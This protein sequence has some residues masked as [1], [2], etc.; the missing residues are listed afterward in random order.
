MKIVNA[1]ENRRQLDATNRC[2]KK[3]RI[4]KP[5]EWSKEA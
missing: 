1:T 5:S 3:S 2:P 4:R